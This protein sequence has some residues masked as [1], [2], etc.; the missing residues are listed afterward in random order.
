MGKK[1]YHGFYNLP[2]E[3]Q[4]ELCEE[5][6]D[7]IRHDGSWKRK[8]DIQYEG[9]FAEMKCYGFWDH[10]WKR[11][12][13]LIE[14]H[15]VNIK[16]GM[17]YFKIVFYYNYKKVMP[18]IDKLEVHAVREWIVVDAGV[19]LRFLCQRCKVTEEVPQPIS[20]EDYVKRSDEFIRKHKDCKEPD[21]ENS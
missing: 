11:L 5:G 18:V 1:Q 9:A 13:P 16:P 20:I 4:N 19:G 10:H 6:L 14:K 3:Y 8:E 12:L 7:P 15:K 17:G 21:N 2:V